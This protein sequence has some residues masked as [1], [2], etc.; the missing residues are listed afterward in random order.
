[1]YFRA[2]PKKSNGP[3]KRIMII[4]IL[5]F[6]SLAS[7]AQSSYIDSTFTNYFRR[8][9]GWT[10]GDATISI[11]LPGGK[12]MWLFGDSYIDNYNAEDNSLPCLFQVRNCFTVQD[13]NN[14][15]SM[16]TYIDSS[17]TGIN[18]T[19]FKIG[20]VGNSVYWPG[21]GFVRKDTV[22]VFL[23]K[24]N[25]TSYKFLGNYIAK[26]QLPTFDLIS[27]TALPKMNGL[28]MGKAIIYDSSSNYYYIYGNKLN[29]IVQEPYVAR[30]TFKNLVS[31]NWKFWT[32]SAW[33]KEAAE[34]K[35]ISSAAV[36]PGFSVIKLENSYYLITQDNG[37]LT[38]GLGRDIYAY[39][40]SSLTGK[41][42]DKTKLY[43]VEDQI[44]GHYLLTYNA[45]A[46]PEF[47]E[48]DELLIGYNVNDMIDTILP[49][50]CPSQ[51]RNPFTD[52]MNADSYRPKFVR[53]PLSVLGLKVG[54]LATNPVSVYP[55]PAT[56]TIHLRFQSGDDQNGMVEIVNAVGQVMKTEEVVLEKGE[57]EIQLN[58]SSLPAGVY[59]AVINSEDGKEIWEKAK[60]M[61]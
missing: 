59:F 38:C 15:N 39:K 44:D 32:G 37:Y 8:T 12:V 33:S 41:F 13:N 53:V 36:C 6:I 24:Y 42:T 31:G 26:I 22:F 52:R 47:I 49:D 14:L 51:C 17:S 1:M 5:S 9:Q 48:N 28:N 27:I 3:M 54:N 2:L 18:Q 35:K 29:W 55:N 30:A 11:P 50:L 25:G 57:N 45:Q 40:S 60:F 34:A 58:V 4:F 16:T 19:Y 43:T 20:S 56:T 10:A 7:F 21:H 46:H 23:E 61:K